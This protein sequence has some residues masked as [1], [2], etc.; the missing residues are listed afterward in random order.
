MKEQLEKIV[1]QL[2]NH[3]D[4]PE[5]L[6][7]LQKEEKGSDGLPEEDWETFYCWS[8]ALKKRNDGE[9][10]PYNPMNSIESDQPLMC[11]ICD[12]LLDT[13]LSEYESL[14]N[15]IKEDVSKSGSH[16]WEWMEMIKLF[17]EEFP[18]D[19]APNIELAQKVIQ[20][21]NGWEPGK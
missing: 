10:W 13:C 18:T 14:A 11:D 15:F 12:C 21:F 5:T 4:Y 1:E 9:N 6:Y 19:Y 16:G 3:V 17:L 7:L 20:H 8:C 2:K